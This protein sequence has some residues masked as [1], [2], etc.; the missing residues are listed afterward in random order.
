MALSD[1]LTALAQRA[2]EAEDRARAAASEVRSDLQL[3]VDQASE[4]ARRKANELA[5]R[6][7]AGKAQTS[8]WWAE[9]QT[10]WASHVA[11]VRNSIS[12]EKEAHD[13]KESQREADDAEADAEA[14]VDFA[15][16]AVEE[17][18]YAVLDAILA[19]KD[20]DEIAASQ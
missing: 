3:H 18:E 19:Q 15:S 9:V 4:S 20:A 5:E 10:D 8:E 14:A 12:A 16:A 17:A 2:K 7:Q 6:A 1:Q 11:K 13:V